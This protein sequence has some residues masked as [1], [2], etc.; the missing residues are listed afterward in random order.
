FPPHKVRLINGDLPIKPSGTQERRIQ[1]IWPI[2]S[3]HDDDARV[4][5]KTIHFHQQ[6]IQCILSFIVTAHHAVFPPC[7]ANG[8]NFVNE[9]DAWCLIFGLAE[10]VSH[11]GST[12]SDKHL[13]EI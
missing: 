1:H 5:T 3:R 4:G 9:Y 8:V 6:L 2:G 13:H 12:H 7:T 10:E 11:A